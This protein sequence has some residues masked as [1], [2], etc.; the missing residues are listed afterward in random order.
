MSIIDQR[1]IGCLAVAQTAPDLF[2][3]RR[4]EGSLLGRCC[5]GLVGRLPDIVGHAVD[6]FTRL[7][8]GNDFIEQLRNGWNQR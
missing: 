3:M 6:D 1:R 7:R 2:L 4:L 8:V 5:L